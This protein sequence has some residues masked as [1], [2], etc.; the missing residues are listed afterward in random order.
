MSRRLRR[1][2]LGLGTVL[3]SVLLAT[4]ACSEDDDLSPT[5]PEAGEQDNEIVPGEGGP[6]N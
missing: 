4:G 6:V 2:R 5:E 1:C 3:I